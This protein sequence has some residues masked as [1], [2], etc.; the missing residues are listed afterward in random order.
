MEDRLSRRTYCLTCRAGKPIRSKHCPACG[1]CVSRFDH[2]CP[3]TNNCIGAG[4]HRVFITYL[5][6]TWLGSAFFSR[7]TWNYFRSAAVADLTGISDG[8]FYSAI[9]AFYWLRE[10]YNQAPFLFILAY[11]I[12][13]GG[14]GVFLLSAFQLYS[15]SR[16]RTTNEHAN[17]GRLEY[18]GTETLDQG[19][20]N[21]CVGFWS[22]QQISK[23]YFAVP[24]H[25]EVMEMPTPLQPK[26]RSQ[27]GQAIVINVAPKEAV[28]RI[29]LEQLEVANTLQP[30][31]AHD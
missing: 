5:F 27:P 6:A 15:V 25:A 24:A 31:Q 20:Y 12:G 29:D 21:N 7:A 14:F 30:N 11:I 3:W 9:G 19:V 23:T 13:S 10:C 8:F 28:G 2:H 18:L 26:T 22:G 4:N 1:Y 16:N 17:H